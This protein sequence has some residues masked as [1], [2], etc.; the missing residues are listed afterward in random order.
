MIYII[1]QKE[2]YENKAN[3]NLVST[4]NCKMVCY[5]MLSLS[6][7][8]KLSKKTLL[9]CHRFA[10]SKFYFITW[11]CDILSKAPYINNNAGMSK[12]KAVNI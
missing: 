2:L 1:K 3:S 5:R 8:A 6:Y 4:C 9:G 10:G 11:L 12:G 7:E